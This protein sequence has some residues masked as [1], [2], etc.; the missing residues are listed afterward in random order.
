M[1]GPTRWFLGHSFDS[2]H[3][4]IK[5]LAIDAPPP[6]NNVIPPQ[7]QDDLKKRDTI[8]IEKTPLRNE[9]DM[10][11]EELAESDAKKL[12]MSGGPRPVQKEDLPSMAKLLT[13]VTRSVFLF[14][15]GLSSVVT[16]CLC[17]VI[18]QGYLKPAI[19]KQYRKQK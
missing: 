17:T 7:T 15:V 2:I 18:Y 19:I 4:N 11:P 9:D 10:S 1:H 5:N 16:L 12:K 6:P 14:Y 8:K 13:N 3:D